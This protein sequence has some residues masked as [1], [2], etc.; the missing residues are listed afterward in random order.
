MQPSLV[1]AFKPPI[2]VIEESGDR[3]VIQVPRVKGNIPQYTF[4]IEPVSPG[5]LTALRVL[6]AEGATEEEL[7]DRVLQMDGFPQLPAFYYYLQ[8]FINLGMLCHTLLSEGLPLATRVP[9]YPSQKFDWKEVAIDQKYRLSRFAYCHQYEGNFV[10][11]SPLSHAKIILADW[12]GAALIAALA[13]PQTCQELCHK[14][15]GIAPETI[16]QFLSLLLSTEM[17]SE[18]QG[19]GK[20]GEETNKAMVSWEFHDLLFHAR[21]RKG[22]HNNPSGKTFRFLDQ[23]EQPPMVKPE[24]SEDIIKLYKPDLQKLQE[25]DYSFTWVLEE[26][27]SIRTYS[28]KPITD[29]QLGEFLYRS[30]RNK[31]IVDKDYGQCTHRP[32]ANS[33]GRYELE[34]YVIVNTCEHLAAGIYHYCPQEHHLGRLTERN[35]LVDALLEEAYF[36]TN[37]FS[38]PQVLLVFAARFQR[39]AWVYESAAY[40]LILKDV[41]SL[42]QTMY[43]VSTAMN[44]APCAVG[45]GNSDLFAAA[46][47][48]DYYAET[49]VGEF[50]LGSRLGN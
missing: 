21:S 46:V 29:K 14:I 30:A 44:L 20:I 19:D 28:D 33:G 5:L 11:E 3:V 39:L 40:S 41:G 4:P 13:Q 35:S 15:P 34:I 25:E 47:G 26:R 6:A 22:R 1:L 32:Y 38:M 50:I 16:Q 9:I 42:Q 45:C 12:Q 24:V 49:S 27:Q 23:L 18:V 31:R 36:A 2:S 48:T 10:L 8:Q 37:Q 43:L 7:S 17:L